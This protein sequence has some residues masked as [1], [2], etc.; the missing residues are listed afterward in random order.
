MLTTP[1]ANRTM[2]SYLGSQEELQLSEASRLA[3][4]RSRMLIIEGYLWEM[5]GALPT[6]LAAISHARASGC[7][8]AL[9]A[10]DVGCV[11]RHHSDFWAAIDTGNVDL[12]FTNRCVP[13]PPPFHH[14]ASQPPYSCLTKNGR[15]FPVLFYFHPHS[16]LPSAQVACPHWRFSSVCQSAHSS[17]LHA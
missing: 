9:T 5:P 15:R 6:I 17:Y 4:S 12:L 3:I 14:W 16:Q 11:Q 7:L 13:P 10:G 1:D 2:L 8:V